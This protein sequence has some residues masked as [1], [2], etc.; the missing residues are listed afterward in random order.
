MR[1]RAGAAVGTMWGSLDASAAFMK[2][3][4]ELGATKA[5]PAD[6]PN[7]V[8]SSAAG[9]VSIFHALRGPSWTVSAFD[10]SGIAAVASAAEEIETGRAD[11]MVASAVE[12]QN[13]VVE[14]VL[15]VFPKDETRSEP[16]TE[17][18]AAVLLEA[19]ET[20]RARGTAFLARVVHVG[21]A[22]WVPG[23]EDVHQQARI[24]ALDQLL[25]VI[26]RRLPADGVTRPR[27]YFSRRDALLMAGVRLAFGDV[28]SEIDIQSVVGS[29]E[30]HGAVG[31][32]HAAQAIARGEIASAV[33]LQE[34]DGAMWAVALAKT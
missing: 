24:A 9:H 34:I 29:N 3:V 4:L 28:E 30:T 15:D 21:Q 22:T 5:M 27:V 1:L 8:L 11:A 14:R 10:A 26:A 33:V 6:F 17:G 20:A 19:E 18:S 25:R 32:A 13:L 2:R 31:A 7:L 12:V 16:R 23:S